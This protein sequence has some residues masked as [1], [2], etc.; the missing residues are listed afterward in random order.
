MYVI[1]QSTG[2]HIEVEVLPLDKKD[3]SVIA[4]NT[5]F[6]FNWEIETNRIFKL[7]IV[8]TK[9][10]LGLLSLKVIPIEFRVQIMLLEV[11]MENVGKKKIYERVAGIL[12]AHACRVSYEEG[13]LGFVSLVPK[14]MLRKH[15]AEKYGLLPM[16]DHM[17]SDGNNSRKLITHYLLNEE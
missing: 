16:A 8:K 10:I 12:I 6:Q 1:Q 3:Y 13:C 11:S 14:T 4:I 9:E 5:G 2:Q 17:A 7:S 15:Y